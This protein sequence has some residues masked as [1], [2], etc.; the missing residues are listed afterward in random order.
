[1]P[2][3]QISTWGARLKI[4]CQISDPKDLWP[5]LAL[6][7]WKSQRKNGGKPKVKALCVVKLLYEPSPSCL[8]NRKAI[9]LTLEKA[10]DIPCEARGEGQDSPQAGLMESSL[11]TRTVSLSA[12]W[13]IRSPPCGMWRWLEKLPQRRKWEVSCRILP[14]QVASSELLHPKPG[15]HIYGPCEVCKGET[16]TDTPKGA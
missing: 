3:C 1:M 7:V 10:P 4:G 8:G 6:H 5:T 11:T 12:R 16:L 15:L 14:G 9:P 13:L 2:V